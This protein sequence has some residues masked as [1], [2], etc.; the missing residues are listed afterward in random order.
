MPQYDFRCKQCQQRFSLFFKT[1]ASYDAAT[2]LCHSCGAGDL[3]RLITQVAIAKPNRDYNRMSSKEMLSVLEAGDKKQVG[4]MFEQV[5][6][7]SGEGT[8]VPPNPNSLPRS[9]PDEAD[10][11]KS[12]GT[13]S[14]SSDKPRSATGN[15]S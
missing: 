2:P 13:G 10:R 4:T 11:R 7:D 15:N 9:S 8:V 5:T 6:G 14:L 1:Y 12:A 3:S